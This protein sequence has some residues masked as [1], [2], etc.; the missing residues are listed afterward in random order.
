MYNS[1]KT[2]V[3]VVGSDSDISAIAGKYQTQT[4]WFLNPDKHSRSSMYTHTADCLPLAVFV[5]Q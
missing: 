3:V 4:S 2:H 1:I 5:L